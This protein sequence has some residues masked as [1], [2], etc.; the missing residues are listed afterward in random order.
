[1][2]GRVEHLEMMRQGIVGY[3]GARALS[4]PYWS[5]KFVCKPT[6]RQFQIQGQLGR[7]DI[8]VCFDAA[9]IVSPGHRDCNINANSDAQLKPKPAFHRSAPGSMCFELGD[10]DISK[11]G[12]DLRSAHRLAFRSKVPSV[13]PGDIVFRA[14]TGKAQDEGFNIDLLCI[15]VDVI[16]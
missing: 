7:A 6:T 4:W 2:V 9:A 16:K 3:V 10:L 12:R 11:Q 14:F 5:S 8:G 15:K 1:M 13:W